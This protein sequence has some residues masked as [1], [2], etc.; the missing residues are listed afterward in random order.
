MSKK[1]AIIFIVISLALLC[2]SIFFRSIKEK[3]VIQTQT[4][5][6]VTNQ[7]RSEEFEKQA[8][9]Y[10]EQGNYKEALVFQNKAIQEDSNKVRAYNN[11]ALLHSKLGMWKEA[12]SD[13]EKAIELGG[14]HYITYANLSQLYSFGGYFEKA[15]VYAD[16]SI[17]MERD[18]ARN[19]TAY[20]SRNASLFFQKKYDQTIRDCNYLIQTG[21]GNNSTIYANRGLSWLEK[22]NLKQ[23]KSDIEKSMSINSQVAWPHYA[24]G[25]YYDSV[26]ESDLAIANYE[27]YVEIMNKS[28]EKMPVYEQYTKMV[29]ERIDSMKSEL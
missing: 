21:L 28:G 17:E 16:K 4:Q 23:A 25:K 11:R 6:P 18:P 14:E 27:R 24:M 19:D 3:P 10:A 15:I 5:N 20:I 26:N 8:L 1:K 12:I 13:A 22:G 2:I 29:K 7:N 9:E